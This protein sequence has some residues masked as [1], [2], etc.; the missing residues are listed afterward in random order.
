MCFERRGSHQPEPLSPFLGR[1]GNLTP[2]V[3]QLHFEMNCVLSS[4]PVQ[5]RSQTKQL[6]CDVIRRNFNS[7]SR[8][9][10]ASESSLTQSAPTL[11]GFIEFNGISHLVYWFSY[12]DKPWIIVF[13]SLS[14]WTNKNL[15]RDCCSMLDSLRWETIDFLKPF[16]IRIFELG[17]R[18]KH[19]LEFTK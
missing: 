8:Q 17:N 4:F 14:K 2:R 7:R 6:H 19:H 16:F 5:R 10:R 15:T 18:I 1:V 12:S 3:G 9:R 13:S 11:A